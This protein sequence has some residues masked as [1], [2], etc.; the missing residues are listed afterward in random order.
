MVVVLAS[1]SLSI[2]SSLASLFSNLKGLVHTKT[3]ISM[4]KIPID[5]PDTLI[6]PDW[7]ILA[8]IGV[9]LLWNSRDKAK[10]KDLE[11]KQEM[12]ELKQEILELKL[13][14]HESTKGVK[15]A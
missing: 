2:V 8:G 5:K 13:L 4:D 6:I 7:W 3:D 15:A 1:N 14:L 9:Y 11:H 12:L 10:L